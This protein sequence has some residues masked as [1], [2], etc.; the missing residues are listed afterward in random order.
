MVIITLIVL[1]LYLLNERDPDADGATG[2]SASKMRSDAKSND[3]TKFKQ[4]LPSSFARSKDAE[5]M[6][7]QVRKGMNLDASY[8]YDGGAGAL[9]FKPFITA[10]TKEELDNM[11]L[12]DKYI[13]EHLYDVGDIVDDVSNNKTGI[14][15]RR[16]TNYVTLEDAD[17]RLFKAWLYDIVETPVVTDDMELREQRKLLNTNIKEI[18]NIMIKVVLLRNHLKIK[19]QVYLKSM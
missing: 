3:F 2:M 4:G 19:K 16:G 1:M 14:I 13:T 7:K 10:S 6:F 17:M 9:R 12:R 8:G 11:V 15:I 18:L 5:D